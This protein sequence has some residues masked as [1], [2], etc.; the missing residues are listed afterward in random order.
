MPDERAAPS[1]H[2]LALGT[3]DVERLARFYREA[4]GLSEVRRQSAEDGELRSVWLDLGG[5]LLMI[6]ASSGA[7]RPVVEGVGA[8]LF[9]LAL[10][11]PGEER[12]AL[13]R[14]LEQ[15]GQRIEARTQFTSY[16]R[17]PDGNRIAV[18]HYP[19]PPAADFR[20]G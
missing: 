18:S 6:E 10:R 14:R 15:L 5:S 13:E 7:A 20:V 2:H 4:F 12:A 19:D 11:V 8:G 1:L 9:L 3:R 16:A 17:D